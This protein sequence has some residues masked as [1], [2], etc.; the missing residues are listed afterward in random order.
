MITRSPAAISCPCSLPED[1]SE[2]RSSPPT[3]AGSIRSGTGRINVL[4]LLYSPRQ[5]LYLGASFTAPATPAHRRRAAR[6]GTVRAGTLAPAEEVDPMGPTAAPRH[7]G[8]GA[9]LAALIG[10][11]PSPADAVPAPFPDVD[12]QDTPSVEVE[13][14]E[15]A[16]RGVPFEL[17]VGVPD[18]PARELAFTVHEA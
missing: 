17:T 14:P 18:A 4:A 16:L 11:A 9:L 3:L 10:L 6:R 13:A 7:A 1:L 12:R 8:G 15:V 5:P 2:P